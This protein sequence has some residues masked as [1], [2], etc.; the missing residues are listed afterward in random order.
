VVT[1]ESLSVMT[2]C[3]CRKCSLENAPLRAE[4]GRLDRY[5]V[6]CDGCWDCEPTC[7]DDREQPNA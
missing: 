7:S 6:A 2:D 5:R 4:P 1:D 3:A